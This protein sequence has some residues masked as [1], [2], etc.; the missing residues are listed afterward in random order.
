MGWVDVPS[1]NILATY[2]Y[3]YQTMGLFLVK[4][5]PKVAMQML[6]EAD[7]M[8]QNTSYRTPARR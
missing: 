1:E 4:T 7:S 5:D 3:L 2:A 6:A 8:V